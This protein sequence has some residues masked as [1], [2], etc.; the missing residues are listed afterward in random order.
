ML[1]MTKPSYEQMMDRDTHDHHSCSFQWDC[2]NCDKRLCI[3]I[4]ALARFPCTHGTFEIIGF[5]NN[6]DGRDHLM[7]VKG[8]VIDGTDILT[9]LHSS[10]LTGDVLGSLRCDCGDQL[11]ESL[12]RIEQEGQGI[13]LYLQQEGRGIGLTNKIKAYMIQDRGLDTYDANVYLGFEP[14]ERQYELAAGMLKRL[15]VKSIRLLTN[16]PRKIEQL[17]KF[18]VVVKKRVPLEIPPNEFNR[19]YLQTKKSR[20][21]HLLTL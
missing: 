5:E 20:L 16:N 19:F 21:G 4:V 12:N 3:R 14:D 7:V 18:G 1:Q 2:A 11:R 15:N 9:R 6:K 10:C 17:A 8:N 13:L